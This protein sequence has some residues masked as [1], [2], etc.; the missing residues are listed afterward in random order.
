MIG[1]GGGQCKGH[2]LA[3]EVGDTELYDKRTKPK[4]NTCIHQGKGVK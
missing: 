4:R 3:A 2:R 1:G